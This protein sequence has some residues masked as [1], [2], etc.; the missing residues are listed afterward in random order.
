MTL[1][2][3]ALRLLTQPTD[4]L[5][6]SSPVLSGEGVRLIVRSYLVS[7]G[8]T[9]E[10]VL[11]MPRADSVPTSKPSRSHGGQ[12]KAVRAQAKVGPAPSVP[13]WTAGVRS[14]SW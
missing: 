10:L 2:S 7:S 6:Q 11:G 8:L 5:M 12:F 14:S 3:T 4:K 13:N 9:S 1:L